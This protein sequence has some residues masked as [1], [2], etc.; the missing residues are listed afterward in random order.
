L[1]QQIISGPMVALILSGN[2]A[3]EV[4]R[5]INGGRYG[6]SFS[7]IRNNED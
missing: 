6:S 5:K 3:I 2:H 7:G 4:V 1:I